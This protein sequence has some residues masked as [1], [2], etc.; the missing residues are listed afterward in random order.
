M[1]VRRS[2]YSEKRIVYSNKCNG[3]LFVERSGELRILA[4]LSGQ[5]TEPK[6][7]QVLIGRKSV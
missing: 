7:Y 2:L 1:E 6:G 3:V 5:A 4:R